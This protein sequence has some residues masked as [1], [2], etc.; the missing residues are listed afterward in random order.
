MRTN[1]LLTFTIFVKVRC[2][3]PNRFIACHVNT[4]SLR[5]KFQMLKAFVKNRTDILL[6][7]KTKLDDSY[8]IRQFRVDGF[9]PLYRLDRN[10]KGR[11]IILYIREEVPSK[12]LTDI[13]LASLIENM[14]FEINLRPCNLTVIEKIIQSQVKS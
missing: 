3:N 14:F 10:K 2:R 1:G 9:V 11:G 8:P 4:N 6:A 13:N 5:N 7:S 12:A